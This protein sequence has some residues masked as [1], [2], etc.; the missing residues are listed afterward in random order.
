MLLDEPHIEPRMLEAILAPT[1]VLA[2]DHDMILDEHTLEIFHHI[3]NSQLCIFPDATHMTPY[4]GP[5]RFN[6]TVDRFFRATFVP[7]DRI[8]DLMKSYEALKASQQ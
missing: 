1:L 6:S 3:P 2:S 4:D 7:K 5:K 8:K